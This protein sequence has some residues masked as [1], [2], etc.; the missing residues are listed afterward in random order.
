MPMLRLCLVALPSPLPVPPSII[1]RPPLS[2]SFHVPFAHYPSR[3]AFIFHVYVLFHV[4]VTLF[5]I[6]LSNRLDKYLETSEYLESNVQS[7]I[8]DHVDRRV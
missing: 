5:F 8:S 1:S 4:D 3:L 6:F 7:V 2:G